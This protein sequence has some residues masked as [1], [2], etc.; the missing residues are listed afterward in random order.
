MHAGIGPPQA[1]TG[2]QIRL[3]LFIAEYHAIR[4]MP[5]GSAFEIGRAG[6]FPARHRGATWCIGSAAEEERIITVAHQIKI[7]GPIPNCSAA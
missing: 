5:N 6:K 2:R 3:G 7:K 4:G 1:G